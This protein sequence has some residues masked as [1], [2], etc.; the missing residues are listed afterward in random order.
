MKNHLFKKRRERLLK[1][2]T[3][4][5]IIPSAN[6]AKRSLDTH[7]DFRQDSNFYYLTG[8]LEPHSILVLTPHL[9]EK[10]HLFL[11]DSDPVHEL[12]EGKLLGV[13]KAPQLLGVDKAYP[14]EEFDSFIK[15]HMISQEVLY[16]D[17]IEHCDLARDLLSQWN[18]F[19]R[20]KHYYPWKLENINHLLSEM[21]LI[22]E[23]EEIQHIQ[24]ACEAT[25]LAHKFTMSYIQPGLNERDVELFIESQFKG[26]GAQAQ[27]YGAIV[28]GG[29][30]ACTLHY[31]ENNKKLK[32]GDLVLIDAGGEY[33][34]YATDITRTIP[35]GESFSKAQKEI[36]SIVLKA[37]KIAVKMVKP[38]AS[39]KKIDMKVRQLMAQ[40]LK[41][42]GLFNESPKEIV[43]SEKFKKLYPHGLGHWLG[44]DTH[45]VGFDPKRDREFKPGMLITIEPGLYFNEKFKEFPKQ[46]RGIGVR[47]EDD[48]LVTKEGN[49]NLTQSCP[50]EIDEIETLRKSLLKK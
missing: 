9:K 36:Y 24:K 35:V 4:I 28:G 44:I 14:I 48:V 5:A 38:G 12:W 40:G 17:Y 15:K 47:I 39:F 49:L 34:L 37:Q 20:S 7:Y 29:N 21:R 25:A 26:L 2:L 41:D 10:T 27:A 1:K 45:D 32:K 16:L 43:A 19:A 11:K 31:R 46:Y 3:G 33:D 42:L 8:F 30:N 23:K 18:K 22:K 50:K 6:E 13:K